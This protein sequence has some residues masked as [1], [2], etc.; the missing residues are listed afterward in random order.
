MA[1]A[2][3]TNHKVR[4]Y[5]PD[6][7]TITKEVGENYHTLNGKNE[8]IEKLYTREDDKIPTVYLETNKGTV[9]SYTG[10]PF[11]FESEEVRI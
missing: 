10:F 7:D 11:T 2:A 3:Y 6:G 1:Q 9:A 8:I 4:I 5:L